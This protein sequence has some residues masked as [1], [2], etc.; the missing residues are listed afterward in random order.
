MVSRL[1]LIDARHAGRHRKITKGSR[2]EP[3]VSQ[4]EVDAPDQAVPRRVPDQP[5][6][7][8]AGVV[9]RGARRSRDV[10]E[11]P[12]RL[13]HLRRRAPSGGVRRLWTPA[14]ALR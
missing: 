11:R 13:H 14:H 7:R 8:D 1:R 6:D 4:E 2:A 10:R 3:I 9:L 12:A 5:Q